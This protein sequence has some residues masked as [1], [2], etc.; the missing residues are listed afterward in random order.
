M[1]VNFNPV[2]VIQNL[3]QFP[4]RSIVSWKSSDYS[5]LNSYFYVS[6]THGGYFDAVQSAVEQVELGEGVNVHPLFKHDQFFFTCAGR[7]RYVY[8]KD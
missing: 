8:R 5:A 7:G 4:L 6:R 2:T 3:S 1:A